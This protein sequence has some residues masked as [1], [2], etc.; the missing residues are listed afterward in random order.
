MSCEFERIEFIRRMTRSSPTGL[1][2][3]IGDDCAVFDPGRFHRLL[4]TTDLL[5]EDV[6]FRRSWIGARLLGR[7]ACVVNV[8][9]LAAM[10]ARPLACQLAL[11][12]PSGF[13]E[14]EFRDLVSGFVTTAERYGMALVGG[15]L[16]SASAL[17]LSVTAMGCVE[18]GEPVLRSGAQPG[19]QL[20]VAGRLGYSRLG[21]NYLT[22]HPDL[23]I[24]RI[25]DEEGLR[26]IIKEDVECDRVLSHLLPDA[27]VEAGQA[28]QQAGLA[29]SMIDVSDGLAS[30]TMHLLE[31]SKV[32]AELS[33][34]SLPIP[35]GLDLDSGLDFVLN[36]G[37]DYAL[38]FTVTPSRREEIAA[39]WKPEWPRP[40][41]VGTITEGIPQLTLRRAG[42]SEILEANG[43]DHFK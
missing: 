4:V 21:L 19:D 2:R 38:V 11:A 36:G 23:G 29:T 28:L 20:F 43:F 5:V 35:G 15:D 14:T 16:S 17:V 24:N 22:E 33:A 41:R 27:L 10:G 31:E 9:D 6:H 13:P 39:I 37:E 7:K 26:R 40:I 25:E 18:S 3:D 42:Q 32:A 34:E 8:S 12:L 1:L 30:D